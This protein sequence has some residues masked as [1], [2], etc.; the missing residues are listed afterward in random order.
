MITI[1]MG[2]VVSKLNNVNQFNNLPFIIAKKLSYE[3]GGFF[4]EKKTKLL[5]N[6]KTGVTYTGLI[7]HVISILNKLDISYNIIDLRKKPESTAGFKIVKPFMPRDYQKEII[8]NA[9]SR[10]IIQAATGAGKTFIMASLIAKFNVKPVLVIAPKVSLALQIKDEFEKFLGIPIG[11]IGGGYNQIEDITI[12]TP[13]SA[14]AKLIEN[15]NALF[16]DEAHSIPQNT[17]F[18]ICRKAKN[19]YY[20]IGVSAT[21]WRDDGSDLL[22]EAALNIRKP[23]LSINASKLIKKQKLSPCQINFVTINNS[24]VDWKGNYFDTYES[25]I[26]NNEFRNNKI[27][28]LAIKSIKE[29]RTLLILVQTIKHGEIILEKLKNNIDIDKKAITINGNNFIVNNIEFVNG[30][31]DAIE[32]DAVFNAVR[33]GFTKILIGTTIADEGLDCPP[34]DTLILAGSGKSSTKAFQRVGRVL[35]LYKG[36]TNAIVYDFRDMQKTF[37]RH[38]LYRK[39]LYETEPEWEIN[40]I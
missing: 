12:S 25:A 32:R 36:K 35:R 24:N 31:Y 29:N 38:F 14:P 23:N 28:D 34:L 18:N 6:I 4:G 21:P 8:D 37:Y 7:P 30:S 33:Q 39:A 5:F 10:E 16:I 26:V 13:Q 15:A 11:I 22:I 27:V 2:N 3:A 9:S 17:I 40:Y 19:A 20:R 1:Q